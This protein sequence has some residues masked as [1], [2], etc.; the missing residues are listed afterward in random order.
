MGLVQ[1]PAIEPGALNL[2]VE[3]GNEVKNMKVTYLGTTTLLFDDS[4]DQVLFDCHISR[5]SI[6]TCLFGR[7]STDKSISDKVVDEF[8]INRLRAIFISHTHYDHV[9]DASY[10]AKKCGADIFGSA[11]ALN[12]ARGGDVDERWL[13]LFETVTEIEIGNYNVKVIPSVHSAAHWYNDDLGKTIDAPLKQPAR[14]KYYKEGGSYDFLVKCDGKSYLIR[15]SYNYLTGQLDGI[16]ADVLF[17]SIA[18]MAGDTEERK[19]HFFKETVDKVSPKI[20]IPIHWDNFFRPLYMKIKTIPGFLNNTA[21]PLLE[22]KN[23]CDSHGIKYLQ[24]MPLTSIVL[25]DGIPC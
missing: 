13:H 16:K 24:Q 19:R 9:M 25:T 23:Y 7:L 10:F 11:S 14:V 2:F 18:G 8:E 15:P 21:R 5:P 17:L 4:T 1:I 6:R 20:V 22:L 12:V 3:E